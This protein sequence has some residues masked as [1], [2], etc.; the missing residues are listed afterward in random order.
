[1]VEPS[2]ASLNSGEANADAEHAQE[3]EEQNQRGLLS[4][5]AVMHEQV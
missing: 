4:D 2:V 3:R 1:M 5:R